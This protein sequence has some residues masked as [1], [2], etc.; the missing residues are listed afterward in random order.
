ML[1]SNQ[2]KQSVKQS[3][4][5]A[6]KQLIVKTYMVKIMFI[7]RVVV[8]KRKKVECD[9]VV[10]FCHKPLTQKGATNQKHRIC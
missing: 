9:Y 7:K 3:E 4:K 6:A 5:W 2:F 10:D 8:W 1:K